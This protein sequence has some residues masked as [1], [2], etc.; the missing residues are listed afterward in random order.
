MAELYWN[1][2]IETSSRDEIKKNQLKLLKN[3]VKYCYEHSAFYRNKLKN[4]GLTPDDIKTLDD[5]Q[6]IPFTSKTDMR[7]NYPFGM[8]AVDIKDIVEI[9]ASSGTTGNPVVGAYTANDMGIWSDLMAR[10]LYCTGVRKTDVMHNAY[11]YG[12]FTGG[13]GFH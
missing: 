10:S 8:L 5:L 6:K 4:A 1:K 3:Q 7:D 12:L 2:K 11:G 13:L 9:H